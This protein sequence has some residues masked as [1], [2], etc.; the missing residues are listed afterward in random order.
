M[1]VK[2]RHVTEIR[3]AIDFIR[4]VHGLPTFA[5]T[6]RA[7]IPGRTPAKAIH[8][9]ELRKALNEAYRAIGRTPPTYTDATGSAGLTIKAVH[10]NELRA[11][12]R[13][14]R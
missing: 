7:L 4:S 14:L 9:V 8:L 13:A 5:W 12:L 10:I 3:D 2:A 1:P 11:S 6:D